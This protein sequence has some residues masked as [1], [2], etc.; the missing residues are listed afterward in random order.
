M[1][2]A[3]VRE[4][5]AA[6]AGPMSTPQARIPA[7]PLLRVHAALI[8]LGGLT[9]VMMVAE[10]IWVY[11][12]K[13]APSW[14]PAHYLDLALSHERALRSGGVPRFLSDVDAADRV[15]A[16]LLTMLAVPVFLLAGVGPDQAVL[17]NLLLWPLLIWAVYALGRRFFSTQAAVLACFLTATYPIVFGLAH[18]FLVEFLLTTLVTVAIALAVRTEGFTRYGASTALGVVVGLGLLTKITFPIYTAGPGLVL[19]VVA[20][21]PLAR[22]D[23]GGVRHGALVGRIVANIGIVAALAMA[24]PIFWYRPNLKPSIDYARWASNGAGSLPY[25]PA[26]PRQLNE[27]AKFTVNMITINISWLYVAVPLLALGFALVARGRGRL[28][29]NWRSAN[30]KLL[31]FGSWFAIP[32][33]YVA[34]SHNHDTRF[35]APAMPAIGLLSA[36]LVQRV[37]P[38]ISRRALIGGTVALGTLQWFAALFTVPFLPNQIA[39][40]RL[41]ISMPPGYYAIFWWQGPQPRA[42]NHVPYGSWRVDE[43]LTYLEVENPAPG[44]VKALTIGLLEQHPVYN[45]NTLPFYAHARNLPFT[46][47]TLQQD[48]ANPDLLST[49]VARCD[50]LLSVQGDLTSPFLTADQQTS[51]R[52]IN[53]NSAAAANSGTVDRFIQTSPSWATPEGKVALLARGKLSLQQAA[54]SH[55]VSVVFSGSIE[56]LGYDLVPGERSDKGRTYYITYYWTTYGRVANDYRVFVHITNDAGDRL[57]ASN[58]HAPPDQAG[59][60]AV[61]VGNQPPGKAVGPTSHWVPG[62]IVRDEQQFFVADTVVPSA[63]PLLIGLYVPD[64]A[65]ATVTDAPPGAVHPGVMGVRIGTFTYP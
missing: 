58:D 62:Q 39:A 27:I 65:L 13:Q 17:V 8:T 9:L 34:L 7:H 64:A 26:Q 23:T 22:K 63:Y 44:G 38:T 10:A 46:F 2:D 49:Q 56:F 12:N 19:F 15:R 45:G 42:S 21:V 54:I 48:P 61:S 35:L 5:A 24:I 16:P 60:P 51:L 18:E 29:I 43:I 31:L 50:Y 20:L 47:V 3:E 53:G 32:F 40:E 1:V 37:P 59:Y 41:R 55:P 30:M 57:V 36:A 6:D 52:L 33:W 28:A 11:M 4:P 25:G 14:D